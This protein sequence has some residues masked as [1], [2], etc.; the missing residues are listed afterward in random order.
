[1]S[2][3]FI[4]AGPI[5][6]IFR[7][8]TRRLREGCIVSLFGKGD[9]NRQFIARPDEA[10]GDILYKWPDLTIRKLTQVTVQPDETALFI[11][12]G[13]VAG[14][15]PQGRSTLD[16]ALIPFLG[17]IVD[18][19]SGGNMYRAELYFVGT[20]EFVELPFGGPIDNIED[21]E[22]GLA[23]GLR[24]FGEYA[25]SVVDP[26]TL[27]L[28]LVGTRQVSNE[29]VT[30][31][32]R[33]Q[34][35]KALRTGVVRKLTAEKW[36]VLGIA[37]RTAEIESAL[38]ADVQAALTPY[39]VK[40]TRL[41][42][43]TISLSPED[44]KTLKGLRKDSAYTRLAGGFREYGVG[45]ALKGIGEGAAAGGG[46][47]TAALG[48]GMGLGGI[49]AGLGVVPGAQ[50]GAGGGT[51]QPGPAGGAAA[52]RSGRRSELC[53]LPR[54]ES[55]QCEV[56]LELRYSHRA[57]QGIALYA[58][59]DGGGARCEVLR[60]LRSCARAMRADG[61]AALFAAGA[62]YGRAGGGGHGGFIRPLLGRPLLD[63]FRFGRRFGQWRSSDFWSSHSSCISSSGVPRAAHRCGSVAPTQPMQS[64]P[65]ALAALGTVTGRCRGCTVREG[66]PRL[67]GTAAQN[68]REAAAQIRARDPGF[69]LEVF[70][71][72]ARDG[73][74]FG[75]ARHSAKRCGGHR[76]PISTI[77]Y[78]CASRAASRRRRAIISMRFWR[79]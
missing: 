22:T 29:I 47:G 5:R 3:S 32:T 79:A 75:E 72:R 57:A 61:G 38:L 55:P 26:A 23:V 63:A 74:I 19:A 9:L 42:N 66:S 4:L 28:T 10:K 2:A 69:E 8:G 71:Q 49:V 59:R 51:F 25:L 40:I 1:M 35:L 34:I 67:H 14:T 60:K 50:P 62:A 7:V 77:G 11:K 65:A 12:E 16:G 56:L 37:A 68:V 6:L 76:G 46:N 64:V 73:L 54:T 20:R 44:E 31:W 21:P 17:D 30:D 15:L 45:A 43:V 18:W 13:K 58:V 24:V 36:P 48:V 27:I 39:G 53:E 78:C 41:G 33:E 70:L 52:V